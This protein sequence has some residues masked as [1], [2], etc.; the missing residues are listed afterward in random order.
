M[1]PYLAIIIQPVEGEVLD[2]N[3]RPLIVDLPPRTINYVSD[4]VGYHKFQVLT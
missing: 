3:R 2:P 1:N 4:L